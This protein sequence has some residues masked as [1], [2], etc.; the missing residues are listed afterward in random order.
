MAVDLKTAQNVVN[1]LR[2]SWFGSVSEIADIDLQRRTWMDMTNRNPHGS[3]IEFACS[4]PDRDQ[5]S[6]A[7]REGWLSAE[8]RRILNDLRLCLD[9]YSPPGDY[10]YD[11]GAV[12]ADPAWR[13]VVE[14]ADRAKQQLLRIVHDQRELKVLLG[15]E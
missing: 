14:A 1:Q 10:P 9:G 4:Y 12:L 2:T 5:V 7:C 15:S 8:E 3:F 11:N 13:S 6:Q